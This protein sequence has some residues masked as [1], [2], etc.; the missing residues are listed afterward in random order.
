MTQ[1]K[2]TIGSTPQNVA[3]NLTWNP[4]GSLASLAITDPFNS[5]GGRRFSH[6]L[7][8]ATRTGDRLP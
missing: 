5:G 4:N 6:S 2:Y 7:P 3:G 1:Y 8:D